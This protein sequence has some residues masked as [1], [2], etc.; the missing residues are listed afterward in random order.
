MK[1]QLHKVKVKGKGWI[2]ESTKS[3]TL[4]LKKIR[5][6]L[7]QF[8]PKKELCFS[9][10]GYEYYEIFSYFNMFKHLSYKHMCYVVKLDPS[11]DIIL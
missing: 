9:M 4:V 2:L 6:K 11:V 3:N 8:L 1:K 10:D 5:M 7:F